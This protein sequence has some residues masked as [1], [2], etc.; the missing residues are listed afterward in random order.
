MIRAYHFVGGTLRNGDPVPADGLWLEVAPPLKMCAHG[1]HASRHPF[2]ALIYAPGDTLCLVDLDGEIIEELDKLVATRRRIV[3]RINAGPMLREFARSC[4]LDV[5]HLWS[6]P[7]V[8]RQYL[9]SG[10]E[11]L[12][13][14]ARDAAMEAARDAA[15]EAARYAATEA[16]WDA[17]GAA[18]GAAA[19]AAATEAAREAARTKQRQLFAD[20]V[21]TEFIAIE[22]GR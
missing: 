12:R 6:A 19:R 20:A 21:D 15:T 17:A 1:L 3:A 18:A 5:I 13:D 10:D 14:A 7:A 9:E 2:D 16:A 4:A 11:S 22:A 8:V